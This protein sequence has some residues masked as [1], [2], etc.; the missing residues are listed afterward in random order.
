ME[1]FFDNEDDYISNDVKDLLEVYK[2]NLSKARYT[3]DVVVSPPMEHQARLAKA[4]IEE[5]MRLVRPF[6]QHAYVRQPRRRCE[7]LCC[8]LILCS[9][10]C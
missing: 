1:T 4:Q 6:V 3:E 5:W 10:W 8:C 9:T 7:S 2:A